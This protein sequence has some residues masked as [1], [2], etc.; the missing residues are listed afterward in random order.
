[1][2]LASQDMMD[3]QGGNMWYSSGRSRICINMIRVWDEQVRKWTNTHRGWHGRCHDSLKYDRHDDDSFNDEG[4][5][6]LYVWDN[7]KLSMWITFEESMYFFNFIETFIPQLFAFA[8]LQR[9]Y[10]NSLSIFLC[11]CPCSMFHNYRLLTCLLLWQLWCFNHGNVAC[12][13]VSFDQ[14]SI[15]YQHNKVSNNWMFE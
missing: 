2:S 10:V 8:H 4:D 7:L 13:T 3:G 14:Y 1:M 9:I 15:K 5:W 6:Q 11:G 12:C